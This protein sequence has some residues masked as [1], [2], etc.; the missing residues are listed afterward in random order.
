ME[1]LSLARVSMDRTDAILFKASD[2]NT[3]TVP[4]PVPPINPDNVRL[5]VTPN[6]ARLPADVTTNHTA[7]P[8]VVV[9]EV[10]SAHFT[11]SA[12]NAD[13]VDGEAGFD[14]LALEETNDRH[15]APLP[16]LRFGIGQP[17]VLKQGGIQF[18]WGAYSA[19]FGASLADRPQ[20]GR[21]HHAS[22]CQ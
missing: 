7:A 5:I 22:I 2:R 18:D 15:R 21:N 6:N 8:V 4:W 12:Y 20:H 10:T 14:W 16:D 1:L 17:K 19:P 13:G 3:H 9:D 11:F